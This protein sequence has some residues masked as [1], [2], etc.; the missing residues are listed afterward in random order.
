MAE[1][2]NKS[3]ADGVVFGRVAATIRSRPGSRIGTEQ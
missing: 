3:S 1:P 2:P